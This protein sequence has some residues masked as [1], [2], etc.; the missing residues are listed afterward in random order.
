MLRLLMSNARVT[1]SKETIIARVWGSESAEENSVEA[2]ISFLRKKLK[3]LGSTVQIVTQRMMGYRL[4][5]A[6]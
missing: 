6:S 1:V 5:E 4:E 2:Y 3:F